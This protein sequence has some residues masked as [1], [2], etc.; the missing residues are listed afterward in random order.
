MNCYDFAKIGDKNGD[1]STI[2]INGSF[3]V[4]KQFEGTILRHLIKLISEA[5]LESSRKNQI[6]ILYLHLDKFKLENVRK[7][8]VINLVK[9]FQLMFPEALYKCYMC[10]SPRMFSCI[11]DIIA[12]CLDTR[13]KS[14]LEFIKT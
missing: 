1:Y 11:Y 8:F 14:K 2:H 10:N 9:S 4:I 3:K 12:N 6:F 5:V 7:D 13:T